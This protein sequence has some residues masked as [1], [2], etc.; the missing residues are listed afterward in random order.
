MEAGKFKLEQFLPK[1]NDITL[2]EE[3]WKDYEYM[4][5]LYPQKAK[6]IAI[7]V[8]DVCDRMEYEGSPMFMEYPDQ[9]TL[10]RLAKQIYHMLEGEERRVFPN[11]ELL[12]MIEVMLC[13]EFFIR[14]SRYHRFKRRYHFKQ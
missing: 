7:L 2:E 9:E 14:R 6:L 3:Q 1:E 13:Q 8:E 4:K 10:Y 12:H 11:D 5:R